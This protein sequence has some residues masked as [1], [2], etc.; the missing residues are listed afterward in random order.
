MHMKRNTIIAGPVSRRALLRGLVAGAGLCLLPATAFATVSKSTGSAI[1]FDGNALIVA[2]GSSLLYCDGD[3][4]WTALPKVS[5]GIIL[6]FTTHPERPGRIV[7]GLDTGG[8][9]LSVD[10]GKSWDVRGQG[11]PEAA[12]TAISTAAIDPDTLYAAIRGDGL[13]QSD[14]VG[15]SWV[16]VMDRPWLG[17][18]ERDVTAL[19]S[20]D[21]ASGMGGIWLYAGTDAGVTRVPDCFC[22]WQDVQSG[23]AMDAFAAGKPTPPE[24]PLPEG[25]PVH[26]LVSAVSQPE[27]LY[28]ALPSGI[29][30]SQDAGVTWIKRSEVI[31]SALAVH[32]LRADDLAI[33]NDDGVL[34]SR[35]GGRT[36]T[37][38]ANI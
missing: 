23:D 6:S 31:A 36:W 27:T 10:G 17:N 37:T 11:L 5:E 13:W 28:A 15:Q 34:Q 30:H 25:E 19:S 29:W 35:H 32:P 16:F 9:V 14:D 20:V 1:A 8:V 33:V 3:Q 21:L 18:A 12:V 24:A 2:R 38:I 26:A 4:N 7:G 22:R